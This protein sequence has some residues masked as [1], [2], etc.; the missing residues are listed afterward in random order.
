MGPRGAPWGPMGGPWGP[1][2]PR[3]A[4][5]GPMVP[6][7]PHGAR[8]AGRATGYLDPKLDMDMDISSLG[9]DQISNHKRG[10]HPPAH[11][12]T[13]RLRAGLAPLSPSQHNIMCGPQGQVTLVC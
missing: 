11:P 12:P 7:G 3:G 8:P 4:L 5:W 13:R 2:E 6:M 1:M 10:D 9:F